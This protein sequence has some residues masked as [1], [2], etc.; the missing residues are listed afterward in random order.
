VLESLE[1]SEVDWRANSG[2]SIVLVGRFLPEAWLRRGRIGAASG[3]M[4]WSRLPH[5]FWTLGNVTEALR[6]AVKI[7]LIPGRVFSCRLVI[8]TMMCFPT[9]IGFD[10]PYVTEV[11]QTSKRFKQ[12]FISPNSGPGEPENAETVKHGKYE[13]F[14][15]QDVMDRSSITAVFSAGS[16]LRSLTSLLLLLVLFRAS[17]GFILAESPPAINSS[18]AKLERLLMMQ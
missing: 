1:L 12:S 10:P 7:G 14:T 18:Y 8:S 17:I 5:M 16:T 9:F 6:F 4:I 15:A 2:I 3:I 11:A 13:S